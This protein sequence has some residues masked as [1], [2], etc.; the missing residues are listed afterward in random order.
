MPAAKPK[1]QAW[2]LEKMNVLSAAN[3]KA[4]L[5][6]NEVVKWCWSFQLS[7]IK[8]ASLL[9]ERKVIGLAK[10]H[11]QFILN[12]KDWEVVGWSS[13][14]SAS[15][16]ELMK[17][18]LAKHHGQPNWMVYLNKM[19]KLLAAPSPYASPD[20]PSEEV[21]VIWI[22]MR[23]LLASQVSWR[24][25]WIEYW[26]KFEEWMMKLSAAPGIMTSLFQWRC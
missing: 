21:N 10:Y 2:L 17:C 16:D 1:R 13:P 24:A 5:F 11:G 7:Q 3:P 6:S 23:S 18:W 19:I 22:E 14:R 20:E 9:E 8:K 25:I 15:W 4:S 26:N 12:G